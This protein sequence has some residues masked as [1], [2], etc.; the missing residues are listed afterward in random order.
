MD[1]GTQKEVSPVYSYAEKA[2]RVKSFIHS[3]YTI[4]SWTAAKHVLDNQIIP[5]TLK[6]VYH[7]TGPEYP[8]SSAEQ[9]FNYL[10][11]V[12]SGTQSV[13]QDILKEATEQLF[14]FLLFMRNDIDSDSDPLATVGVEERLDLIATKL[15]IISSKQIYELFTHLEAR[16][17][18]ITDIL[19]KLLLLIKTYGPTLEQVR[20]D[21]EATAG[22]IGGKKD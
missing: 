7:Y 10:V 12:V 5:K 11:A 9:Y 14:T 1:Q 6:Q 19:E 21:Y 4:T 16:D 2:K 3:K 18:K 22:K 15:D 17:K 8:L 20:K 13:S